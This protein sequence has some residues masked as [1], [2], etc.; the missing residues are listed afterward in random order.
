MYHKTGVMLIKFTLNEPNSNF[1]CIV[2]HAI[3]LIPKAT[4]FLE[5]YGELLYL[6]CFKVYFHIVIN[7]QL[8]ENK[9][10]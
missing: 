1:Y 4:F 2:N 8:S 7:V 3:A 6:T 5:K 9:V 10:N